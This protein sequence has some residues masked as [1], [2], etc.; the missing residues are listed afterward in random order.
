[1]RNSRR[2]AKE[3]SGAFLYDRQVAQPEEWWCRTGAG[4]YSIDLETA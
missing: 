1:M 4:A 3:D 2:G